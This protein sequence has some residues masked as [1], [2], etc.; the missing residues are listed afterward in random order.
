VAAGKKSATTR[1]R[2]QRRARGSLSREEILAAARRFIER[3]GLGALS[4]PRLAKD[5]NAGATSLYWY[6]HSKD[7]L[8]DAL[9]DAITE[10][11]YLRLTP[12]GDGPWD[13][14]IVEYHVRFRALVESSS[15]YRDVFAYRAR[16]FFVG[17][18]MAPCILRSIEEDL[19][20]LIRA[21]LSP[22][23]AVR[24]F[25]AFAVYTRAFVLADEGL[26]NEQVDQDALERLRFTFG[27]MAADLPRV[28]TLE[29]VDQML[30]VDETCFRGALRFLVA[31][32]CV[33][34][35]A[36]GQAAGNGGSRHRPAASEAAR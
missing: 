33:R 12:I 7:D 16:T 4:F 27:K 9:V 31:G 23:E 28:S 3:D 35:P 26:A 21:G 22:E 6:F 17:K 20:I 18:R 2:G 32:L 36:L 24:A 13:E 29:R 34:H 1:A 11:M 5:L 30:A 25:N 10:E 8:L 15:V 19:A 14:E